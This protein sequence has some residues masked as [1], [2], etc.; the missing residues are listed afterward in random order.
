MTADGVYGMQ[1]NVQFDAT[2]LQ[3]V[4]GIEEQ[5]ASAGWG[6]DFPIEN[7]APVSGGVRVSGTMKDPPHANPATLAGQ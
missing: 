1:L 2:N 6:W 3:F 4:S 7:F 5:C